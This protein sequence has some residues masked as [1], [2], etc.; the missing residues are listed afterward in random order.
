LADWW[1]LKGKVVAVLM[2]VLALDD[3][4]CGDTVAGSDVVDGVDTGNVPVEE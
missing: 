3:G 4:C 2:L 1:L